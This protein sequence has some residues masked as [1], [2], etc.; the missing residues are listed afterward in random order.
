MKR[1][2]PSTASSANGADLGVNTLFVSETLLRNADFRGQART[3]GMTLF[4][5]FPVF[6]NPEALKEDPGLAAV[7]AAGGAGPRGVGGIRLPGA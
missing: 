5:I 7:T 2:V 4:L 1:L 3:S 6:Q